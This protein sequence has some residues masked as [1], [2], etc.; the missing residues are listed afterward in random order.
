[1][2]LDPDNE[3]RV[4]TDVERFISVRVGELSGKEGFEGGLL[5]KVQKALLQRA[6]GTFL[7]V[8]FMVIELLRPGPSVSLGLID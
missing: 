8:G 6:D 1:M 7:W 2:K 4:T 5:I 3:E